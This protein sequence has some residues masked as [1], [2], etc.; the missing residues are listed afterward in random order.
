[1]SRD[2]ANIS[3]QYELDRFGA[4]RKKEIKN[5][6]MKRCNLCKCNRIGLLTRKTYTV[7]ISILHYW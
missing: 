7:D 5:I 1:M 2:V 4:R 3:C 6:N